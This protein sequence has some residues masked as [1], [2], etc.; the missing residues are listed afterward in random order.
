M[1]FSFLAKVDK[2]LILIVGVLFLVWIITFETPEQIKKKIKDKVISPIQKIIDPAPSSSVNITSNP[3][4]TAYFTQN[5][6][7]MKMPPGTKCDQEPFTQEDGCP[8]LTEQLAEQIRLQNEAW[9]KARDEGLPFPENE[10]PTAE[11]DYIGKS[12]DTWFNESQYSTIQN[13]INDPSRQMIS[14]LGNIIPAGGDTRDWP[15]LYQTNQQVAALILQAL[16]TQGN[17]VQI[18]KLEA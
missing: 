10:G 18:N 9:T 13:L 16:P 14:T 8:T 2:K 12:D 15:E 17:N 1:M 4:E 5:C 7:G 3:Y 6:A 11:V